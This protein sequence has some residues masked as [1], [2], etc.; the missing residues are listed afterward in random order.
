[1]LN[2]QQIGLINS[3]IENDDIISSTL[4]LT[5]VFD[6]K[7]P[8]DKQVQ[9]IDNK[10][11]NNPIDLCQDNPFMYTIYEMNPFNYKNN[12]TITNTNDDS[13]NSNNSTTTTTNNSIQ[14]TSS[15]LTKHYS[16]NILLNNNNNN[17]PID[18]SL[19]Q[20]HDVWSSPNDSI[21]L[22]N[23]NSDVIMRQKIET[24][25][26]QY[27]ENKELSLRNY[28]NNNYTSESSNDTME[29]QIISSDEDNVHNNTTTI[30]DDDDI[31]MK[32]TAS[33]QEI[34]DLSL[35]SKNYHH[36][37]HRQKPE[38]LISPLTSQQLQ[39]CLNKALL[40]ASHNGLIN[41]IELL[42]NTGASIHALDKYGR[43]CLHLAAKFGHVKVIEYLLKYIPEKLIDL[44]EYEKN[45]TALHKAAASRRRVICKILITAGACPIITDIYGKQPSNLALK[46]NDPQ[47]AT[48]LKR[49]EI[50]FIIKNGV[51]KVDV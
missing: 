28:E 23:S 12:H 41:Y 51:E 8:S 2:Q 27:K 18:L 11:N 33:I 3:R 19:L 16:T 14:D 22:I 24:E 9:Q 36:H 43:S 1:M 6:K 38:K 42:L 47:L 32:V 44:Q 17:I 40:R 39:H 26:Q 29:I 10:I 25:F 4:Y 45:Q 37:H 48:Y 20:Q 34:N 35:K 46:A 7:S 13:D 50:L 5:Q 30:N 15:T 49:E 31:D 21:K